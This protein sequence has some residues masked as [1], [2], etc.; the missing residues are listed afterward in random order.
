[1]TCTVNSISDFNSFACEDVAVVGT[2]NVWFDVGDQVS[3]LADNIGGIQSDVG[4]IVGF[5]SGPQEIPE[6]CQGGG[7]IPQ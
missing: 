2:D 7:P 1:M 4:V 6:E 3:V 5:A